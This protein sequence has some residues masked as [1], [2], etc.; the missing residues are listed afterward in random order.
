MCDGDVCVFGKFG[1]YCFLLWLMVIF[2]GSFAGVV[3]WGDRILCC[4]WCVVVFK[5]LI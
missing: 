1:R 2:L 5:V 4:G 3:V